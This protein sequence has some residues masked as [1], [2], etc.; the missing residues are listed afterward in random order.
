MRTALLGPVLLLMLAGAVTGC[1]RY[2]WSKSG[3]T[4]EQFA[5]DNQGCL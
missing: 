1:S 2:Y 3:A 5:Q 4:A